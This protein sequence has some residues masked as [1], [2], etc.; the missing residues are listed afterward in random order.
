MT[1]NASHYTLPH[2]GHRSKSYAPRREGD[3]QLQPTGPVKG[4]WVDVA[5]GPAQGARGRV[6]ERIGDNVTIVTL[7][8]GQRPLLLTVAA[9]VCT[10]VDAPP[11][12]W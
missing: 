10:P 6:I 8:L 2:S 3:R 4:A 11:E 7:L 12:R 5:H 1:D 9:A